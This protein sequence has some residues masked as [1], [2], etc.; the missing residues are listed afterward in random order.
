MKPLKKIPAI[1]LLLVLFFCLHG[2]VENF[3]FIDVKEVLYV[4][5]VSLLCLMVVFLIVLL[6]TKDHLFAS[7]LVFFIGT[8]YLF[9]GAI[10]DRIT[11]TSYLFLLRK[12]IVLLPVLLTI[13]VAWIIFLNGFISCVSLKIKPGWYCPLFLL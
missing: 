9:F 1:L 12:Y 4:G 3:G 11:S 8:W 5:L 13:T 10:H 6:L 2:T 7:L